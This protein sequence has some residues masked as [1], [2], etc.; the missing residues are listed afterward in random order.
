MEKS[1]GFLKIL[2]DRV[3]K[4]GSL[5]MIMTLQEFLVFQ[6]SEIQNFLQH[7]T[8]Q[9]ELRKFLYE[10]SNSF[11]DCFMSIQSQKLRFEEVLLARL[12]AHLFGF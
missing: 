7:E 1:L 9:L 4:K 12:L 8:E 11:H 2:E 6:K 3:Q 5:E 10:I